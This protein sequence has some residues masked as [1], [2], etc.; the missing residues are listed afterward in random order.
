MIC[1]AYTH[2]VIAENNESAFSDDCSIPDA[3]FDNEPN[4]LE[5]VSKVA[6][7][8]PDCSADVVEGEDSMDHNS[9]CTGL[10][11]EYPTKNSS[12]IGTTS[13]NSKSCVS[14]HSTGSF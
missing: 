14:N 6:H 9:W 10:D 4:R 13:H 1:Y 12:K 11:P 7:G 5:E 8:E 3:D 2:I